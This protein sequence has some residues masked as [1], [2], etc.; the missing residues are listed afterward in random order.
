MSVCLSGTSCHNTR[1]NV[2]DVE[3]SAFS[4]YFLLFL[5]AFCFYLTQVYQGVLAE[6]QLDCALFSHLCHRHYYPQLC[7]IS[8]NL[9]DLCPGEKI[10]FFEPISP[11]RWEP[12]ELMS[13]S[14]GVWQ[15]GGLH[16]PLYKAHRVG[17]NV[18]YP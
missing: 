1:S 8:S 14:H 18:R 7:Y 15:T 5:F 12:S 16:H 6:N 2:T 13:N 17:A 4:E 9:L 11:I 10:I 3:V